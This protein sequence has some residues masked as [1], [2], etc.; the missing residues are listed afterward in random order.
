[1]YMF[2]V[3]GETHAHDYFELFQ[4]HTNFTDIIF[5]IQVFSILYHIALPNA[6]MKR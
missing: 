2:G 5:P 1:M 6:A 3:M 4:Q